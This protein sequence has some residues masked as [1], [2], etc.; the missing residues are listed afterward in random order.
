MLLSLV[1]IALLSA[2]LSGMAGL[3]GGTILIAALFAFGI[4]PIQAVALH[5]LVQL[6]SNGTRVFAYLS[7]VQFSALG[8]FAVGAVPAPFLVA[9]FAAGANPDLLRLMLG[10]FVL[11][12]L[13]PQWS[14]W[15][16]L[17]GNAGLV[18]AGLIAGGI[19]MFIGATGL[20]LAPFFLARDWSKEQVIATLAIT[21]CFA[22]GIKVIAFGTIDFGL[23]SE[24]SLWLP[25]AM[26]VVIGTFIGKFL[27]GRVSERLFRNL[28][29]LILVLLSAQLLYQAVPALWL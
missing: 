20:L 18:C 9:P 6:V 10:L 26:A 29:R 4:P 16:R 8:W 21:Q 28:V 5:A 1:L 7:H 2:A 19:G 13:W 27:N 3:G 17:D 12:T 23:I 14:R 11:S 24:V 25:M 15:L 22:H